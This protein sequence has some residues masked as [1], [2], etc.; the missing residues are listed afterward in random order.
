MI[1]MLPI[2]ATLVAKTLR[3]QV[4]GGL[5]ER[6]VIMFWHGKMFAGWYA[7]V[8]PRQLL[9]TIQPVALVSASKDGN[10]LT[11]VLNRWGYRVERGSSS[12]SG[13]EALARAMARVKKGECRRVVI[14]PDGPRG[15]HHRLKR[16]AFLAAQELQLPIYF[17]RIRYRRSRILERSWDQ[18]EIPLPFSTVHIKVEK[19][20]MT[21]FPAEMHEQHEWLNRLASEMKL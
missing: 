1:R 5:P 18:F 17:L 7:S 10:I 11:S 2:V 13:L 16:G 21:G 8:L 19:I 12:K 3:F 20:D 14:T 9:A 15:P 6:C 4:K